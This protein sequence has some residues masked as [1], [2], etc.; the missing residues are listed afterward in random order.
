MS[1]ISAVQADVPRRALGFGVAVVGSV[2]MMASSSLPSPFYPVLQSQLGFSSLMLTV[3]FAVYALAVLAILLVCGSISDHVGRRPVLCVGFL[4]LAI[5]AFAFDTAQT[6]AGLGLARAAQGLACGLLIST[7]SAT[8]TDLEPPTMPGMAAVCNSVLPM[9][10]MGLG[11]LVSGVV[12]EGVD[13]PKSWVFVGLAG[14]SLLL[15]VAIWLLPETSPRHEGLARALIPRVGLP[16]AAR[17]AFWR[18]APALFAGWGTG[19]LYLSLGASIMTHVFGIE[20]TVMHGVVVALLGCVGALSCFVARRRSTRAI[21]LYGTSALAL[22]TLGCLAGILTVNLWLY[23][24]ALAFVGTGFGVAFYGV[25]RT[26]VPLS[27]PE[28]RGELFAAVFT[29]S[30]LAFGLP[31]VLAGMLV[32]VFGLMPTVVGYGAIIVLMAVCA[33]GFRFFLSRD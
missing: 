5:A 28:S 3:I 8:I 1:V 10:G 33:G 26:I 19:A 11:A 21:V 31:A 18:G 24:A 29:L 9:A 15:A 23:L 13:N 25:I 22:G 20:D 32:P 7:L 2:L 17:G 27:S 30:Y 4:L 6:A 16:E 12:M 14:A